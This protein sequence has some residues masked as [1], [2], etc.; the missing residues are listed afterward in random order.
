MIPFFSCDD[1]QSSFE[2]LN[3][4]I[5]NI[6]QANRIVKKHYSDVRRSATSCIKQLK[7]VI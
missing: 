5:V 7:A 1:W 2:I 6:P 4:N 3:Q